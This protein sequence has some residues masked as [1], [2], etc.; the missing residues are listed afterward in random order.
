MTSKNPP[1]S[2]KRLLKLH[3]RYS[4]GKISR[5]EFMRRA[6]ALGLSTPA[7]LEIL[8]ESSAAADNPIV[9][10]NQQP[11]SGGWQLTF[12]TSNDKS[13]QIKGYASATSV[14][15]GE[16]ITFYVTVNPA[17]PFTLDV[18]R[19]GW[20]QGSGG[21]LLHHAGPFNGILQSSPA[22]NSSTGLIVCNWVPCYTLSVPTTWTSGIYLVVLTNA[23]NYQTYIVFVVRDDSRVAPL[24]Y[25]QSVTTY[26]AYNNYPQ[27]GATGKSLYEYNSYGANTLSGT[28]R[29]VKVSFDR[30]YNHDWVGAGDFPAWEL[31]FVRWLERSGYD[32]TY[33]T[34][35]DTHANGSR[36]LNYKGFL[37]V[38]HD[39]YWSR[40]M[41]DAAEAARDA[42][43]GLAFFGANDCCWQVRFEASAGGVPNRVMVCYKDAA[44]DPIQG[45]T[46]TVNW[47]DSRLNRPEQMLIGIQ[48]TSMTQNYAYVSYVVNNSGHWVYSGTGFKDGDSVPGILG[49]EA[50]NQFSSSPQPNFVA[51][52]YQLLSRSPYT[53]F[54]SRSDYANSSIYQAPSGAWVFG[55]GS[56]AWSWGLDNYGSHNVADPRIQQL[57][58]NVLNKFLT[59]SGQSGIAA[60]SNLVATAV[61][62]TSVNLTW[63]DNSSN[64]DNFVV[65]RSSDQTNWSTVTLPANS[66]SYSD[67]GLNPGVYYY[68]VK[69][70]K[71]AGT[72]S[73]YSN[74]ATADTQLLSPTFLTATSPSGH[75]V[76]LSWTDNASSETAYTVE[77]SLDGSTNWTVLSSAS[78]GNSNG[79]SDVSVNPLT[80]YYYRVKATN[81]VGSSGYSNT[82]SITTRDDI[83][84]A[85]SN[86]S[87]NRVGKRNQSINLSWD[88]NSNN[89][90]SFVIQRAT[91]SSFTDSL[92]VI[93]V[94]ANST[95]Y[96]DRSLQRSTTYYYRVNASNSQGSSSYS[97]VASSTTR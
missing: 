7:L 32:V 28:T 26:L 80:T 53:N 76:V 48:Y 20:Y 3:R 83:P 90:T 39:E 12:Y 45:P 40:E 82:S 96:S 29:A 60:P 70:T 58:A 84:L 27:D 1:F 43:V 85:P 36:L 51:G 88:D 17:Q 14:N 54:A 64:E 6:A 69:A 95:S 63:S 35:V 61:S 52:T 11:G 91:D 8:T 5:R 71:T 24:L 75:K 55:A 10:E 2:G 78:P 86:L 92:T 42:G 4:E 19:I 81:A 49:Y 74:T 21:R 73:N 65:E 18:Y 89:E 16:P 56:I 9:I 44:K 31:Y 34:D 50:D 62:A 57:T 22:I 67:T 72:S 79:Y 68:R 41:R 97:N 38:G 47:R 30:P 15:K 37:S 66:F 25:Q 33:S 59:G 93:E 23:Q 77:R 87:A 94:P 13:G 46:T